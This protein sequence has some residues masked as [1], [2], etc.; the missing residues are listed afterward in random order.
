MTEGLDSG[1]PDAAS[2][3]GS[4]AS[5]VRVGEIARL[6]LYTEAQ[7]RK[8]SELEKNVS[9]LQHALDTRV[10]IDRAVGM[11]SE[12]FN[13]AIT[14]AFELLRAAARHSRRTVRA[15]ATEMTE[16][17]GKTPQE[18]ADVA[19]RRVPRSATD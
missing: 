13:V 14:D 19:R 10:V 16:S 8:I 3:D 11:L 1:E 9:D 12:R 15:L 17:R 18:V 6:T 5:D 4:A 7:V 2:A